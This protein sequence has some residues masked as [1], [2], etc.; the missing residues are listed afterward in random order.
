ME[1]WHVSDSMCA[2]FSPSVTTTYA[3]GAHSFKTENKQNYSTSEG[4][5]ELCQSRIKTLICSTVNMLLHLSKVSVH[6]SISQGFFNADLLRYCSAVSSGESKGGG[7]SWPSSL[8]EHTELQEQEF[9][10]CLPQVKLSF[11]SSFAIWNWKPKSINLSVL[12]ELQPK[13]TGQKL[14]VIYLFSPSSL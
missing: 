7:W 5:K 6:P 12:L 8:P 10:A 3:S 2:P 9:G 14:Y 13:S 4:K 11:Q 1:H